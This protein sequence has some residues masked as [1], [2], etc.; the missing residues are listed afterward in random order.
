MRPVGDAKLVLLA[1][2]GTR[3]EDFVRSQ[4]RHLASKGIGVTERDVVDDR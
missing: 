1:T 3:E 2:R 4:T